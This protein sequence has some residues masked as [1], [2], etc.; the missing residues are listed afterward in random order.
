M[1]LLAQLKPCPCYKAHLDGLFQE[2]AKSCPFKTAAQREFFRSPPERVAVSAT[3]GDIP[4]AR[5]IE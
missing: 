3:P 5:T 1:T 4:L 2:A